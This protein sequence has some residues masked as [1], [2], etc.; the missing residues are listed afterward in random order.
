MKRLNK[1][2]IKNINIIFII[3][4]FI[5]PIIDVLTAVS[6]TILKIDLTLGIIIRVLFMI[7]CLYY[8]FFLNKSKNNKTSLIYI[9]L[10][11]IYII[12]FIINTLIVKGTGTIVFEVKS[13]IKTFYFPILLVTIYNL[14]QE[15]KLNIELKS[16]IKLFAIY[17]LLVFI[18]NILNVGFQSYAVTKDGEIGW[19]YTA[20]EIG[21]IISIIMPLFIYYILEKKN[22][23]LSII[24]L[25]ILLYVLTS[26][27]T[28]GP[29][30]C[31]G[32][33]LIYY[34]IKQILSYISNKNYIKLGGSIISIIIII[35]FSIIFIPKTIFYK[36]ICTHIDF[37]KVDSIEDIVTNPKILDHFIFSQRLTFWSKTNESYEESNLSEKLLGIGYIENYGT[38]NVRIKM[39]EMDYVDIFYRHGIIGFIIFMSSYIYM[40]VLIIKKLSKDK[41]KDNLNQIIMLSI[42]LSIILSMLTG[43]VLTSPSVSIYV[44]LIINLFYNKTRK[45]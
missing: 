19:F 3:F 15:E 1:F 35:F 16:I 28:K 5:Q 30:L 13:L 36:N 27:G 41:I 20:N 31:F 42:I 40:F 12:L 34:I 7:F 25:L 33:I 26:M 39:I 29:L 37:L 9:S 18:P 32:I 17:L 14:Y 10:L 44:A 38:D 22:I 4:L 6:L 24:S 23:I 43:H 11:I 45:A 8:L 21:A 2:L